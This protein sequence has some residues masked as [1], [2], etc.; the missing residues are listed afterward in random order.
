MA[1]S[2]G[3][4]LVQVQQKAHAQGKHVLAASFRRLWCS[5][6]GEARVLEYVMC[7]CRKRGA[8]SLKQQNQAQLP[9]D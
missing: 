3:N 7:E 8:C 9:A 6:R 2:V 4:P 1:K 5:S